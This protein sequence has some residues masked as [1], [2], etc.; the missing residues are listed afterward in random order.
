MHRWHAFR[1]LFLARLREFYREPEAIFWVYLFPIGMAWILS[2]AFAGNTSEPS[3]VDVL[4]PP[5][6]TVAAAWEER[7]TAAKLTVTVQP[8]AQALQR[9]RTGKVALVLIPQADGSV[10]YWL[11]PTRPE[12][13]LARLEVDA[14]VQRPDADARVA[15][16]IVELKE[17]GT[18]YIDFLLP[19]LV[20][21]NLLGSGMMGVGFLIVDLRVRKVM[22][23]LLATP[24]NRSDFLVS[25]LTSRLALLVPEVG[26][27]GIGLGYAFGVPCRGSWLAAV[28]V[29]VLGALA[30]SGLGI[31]VACRTEKLETVSG[32]IN[33]IM[34]PSWL[35]SGTFFSAKRF[36]EVMQPFIQALPL[37]QINDA[38]REIALEGAGLFDVGWRLM[39]L[40]TWA[41]VTFT[42]GLRWFRWQ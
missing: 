37:T 19:G 34:L 8:E 33:V 32:L 29:V 5:G 30:F 2:M 27:I 11:D 31:L 4:G 17:P 12:S 23:R 9:L 14:V 6:D 13:N 1:E 36:P 25:M 28:L 18:R 21:M 40:A 20:G 16:D 3:S 22:K 15:T 10:C 39:I 41:L 7:L 26:I 42:L 38:L 24:M 35:L